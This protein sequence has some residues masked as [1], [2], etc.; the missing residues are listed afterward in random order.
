MIPAAIIRQSR[1]KSGAAPVGMAI[2]G[3]RSTAPKHAFE[4]GMQKSLMLKAMR[5][6]FPGDDSPD[7]DRFC[8]SLETVGIM[9]FVTAFMAIARLIR[10]V[11]RGWQPSLLE[12]Y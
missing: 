3:A 2:G 5:F 6:T 4:P 12:Q 8:K 11:M 9:G 10:A 1:G 7:R